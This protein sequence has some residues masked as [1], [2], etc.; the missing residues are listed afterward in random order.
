MLFD[1]AEVSH[2]D[3]LKIQGYRNPKRIVF[4]GTTDRVNNH[5]I[6]DGCLITV[7]NQRY[8]IGSVSGYCDYIT[9][10]ELFKL[11]KQ[12][13]SDHNKLTAGQRAFASLLGNEKLQ[14]FAKLELIDAYRRI[15]K[16]IDMRD[17]FGCYIRKDENDNPMEVILPHQPTSL[18]ELSNII[19][20]SEEAIKIALDD[21]LDS[22]DIMH[23]YDERLRNGSNNP[24]YCAVF[25]HWQD[26]DINAVKRME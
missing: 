14:E 9:H 23:S 16:Q 25:E 20:R 3:V 22:G 17:G 21:L 2:R 8:N 12:T 6:T 13:N 24:F 4:D 18:K 5:I 19:N 26:H 15:S 1:I 10:E 7:D 11:A